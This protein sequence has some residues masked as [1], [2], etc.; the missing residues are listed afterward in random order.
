MDYR[1][2]GQKSQPL[3]TE[4]DDGWEVL[5]DP[6]WSGGLYRQSSEPHHSTPLHTPTAL[7][8]RHHLGAFSNQVAPLKGLAVDLMV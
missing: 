2:L 6:R 1:F 5:T 4:L 3:V 8:K 7:S